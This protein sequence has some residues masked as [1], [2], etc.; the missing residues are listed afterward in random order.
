MDRNAILERTNTADLVNAKHLLFQ[1]SRKRQ[2]PKLRLE[3][4]QVDRK[5]TSFLTG[6]PLQI[7]PSASDRRNAL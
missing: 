5:R 3:T 6:R 7:Q 1:S 4:S 2:K